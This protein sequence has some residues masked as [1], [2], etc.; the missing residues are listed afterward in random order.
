MTKNE[1]AGRLTALIDGLL[2]HSSTEEVAAAASVLMAASS[3]L[4]GSCLL[5]LARETW[6]VLD[7]LKAGDPV[8]TPLPRKAKWPHGTQPSPASQ[9]QPFLRVC[10]QDLAEFT[11]PQIQVEENLDQLRQL[12]IE[13]LRLRTEA[14]ALRAWSRVSRACFSWDASGTRALRLSSR[15]AL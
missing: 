9:P 13:S 7:Q 11:L 8:V 4:R 6:H 2:P 12:C 3:A 1:L 5:A 10:P 14:Q 15:P